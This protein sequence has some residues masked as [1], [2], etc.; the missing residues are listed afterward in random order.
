MYK[1]YNKEDSLID[2]TQ[3]NNIKAEMQ[4]IIDETYVTKGDYQLR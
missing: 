3:S 2:I 1:F 4:Q